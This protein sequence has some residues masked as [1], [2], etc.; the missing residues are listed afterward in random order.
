MSRANRMPIEESPE[1][2]GV[3]FSIF[4]WDRGLSRLHMP[5]TSIGGF[6]GPARFQTSCVILAQ[7]DF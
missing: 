5:G 1:S 2:D 7:A 6:V 3:S 4:L